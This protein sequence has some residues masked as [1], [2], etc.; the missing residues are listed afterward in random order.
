MEDVLWKHTVV[1]CRIRRW[2]EGGSLI[3]RMEV[4]V[5]EIE[6]GSY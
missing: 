3:L 5:E 6:E 1:A 4:Y 2:R